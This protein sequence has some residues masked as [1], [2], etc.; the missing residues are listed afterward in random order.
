MKSICKS[1]AVENA[2]LQTISERLTQGYTVKRKKGKKKK[3]QFK[4]EKIR[5]PTNSGSKEASKI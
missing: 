5:D 1:S 4:K 3:K 2:Q